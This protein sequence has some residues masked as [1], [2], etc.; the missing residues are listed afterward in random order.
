MMVVACVFFVFF[1]GFSYSRFRG[2][3]VDGGM[4]FEA[5]DLELFWGLGDYFSLEEH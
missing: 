1:K 5:G 2:K 4:G 3:R